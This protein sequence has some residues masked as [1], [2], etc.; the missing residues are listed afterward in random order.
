M[1]AD[2]CTGLAR[3]PIRIGFDHVPFVIFTWLLEILL[4]KIALILIVLVLAF[5]VVVRIGVGTLASWPCR[6]TNRVLVGQN[7]C[8][9]TLMII[10]PLGTC[11]IFAAHVLDRRRAF[12]PIRLDHPA[13]QS[14]VITVWH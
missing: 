2:G 8:R 4:C 3:S 7:R 12:H 5:P 9:T 1:H 13:N 10:G 6:V 14:L 11:T